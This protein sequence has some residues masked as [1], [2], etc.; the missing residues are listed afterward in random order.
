MSKDAEITNVRE[1]RGADGSTA[2]E[3]SGGKRGEGETS[4]YMSRET[5]ADL[6]RQ[7]KKELQEALARGIQTALDGRKEA[8]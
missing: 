7:G 5:F 2:Y 6:E 8:V 3:V 1:V 4:Y